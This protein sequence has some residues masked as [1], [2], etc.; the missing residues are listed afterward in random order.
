MTRLLRLSLALALLSA[1]GDDSSS[2]APDTGPGPRPDG[3]TGGCTGNSECDDGVACTRDLCDDETGECVNLPEGPDCT[4]SCERNADCDDGVACTRDLCD[5]E[6]GTCINAPDGPDCR[7]PECRLNAECD[8]DIDC[9][10]DVCDDE[11][12]ECVNVPIMDGCM[13]AECATAADCNDGVACTND[14]CTSGRCSHAA[15]ASMCPRDGC[16]QNVQCDPTMGCVGDARV[17]DD[18][19]ACTADSCD[20]A[21]GCVFAPDDS[22]CPS[23]NTCS[24]TEG[25]SGGTCSSAADCD[26]GD[27]CTTDQCSA[28]RCVRPPVECDDGNQCTD[29]ECNPADGRCTS[30]PHARLCDDGN[31]C[32]DGDRCSGGSCR[33]TPRSCS[34]GNPCT[35]DTCNPTSGAC[36]STITPSISCED[37]DPCTMGT[38]CTAAGACT[39]GSGGCPDDGNPCTVETCT[40]SGCATSNAPNGMSCGTGRQ[41]CNGACASTATDPMNCGSCGNRCMT[42]T[43]ACVSGACTTCATDADCNDDRDCTMDVCNTIA[44]RCEHP[45]MPG[46]CFIGGSCYSDNALNP[47]EECQRCNAAGTPTVWAP[48]DNAPCDDGLF[49]TIDD[50]CSPDGTC[51]RTTPNCNDGLGCTT[52][53]C[54]EATDAC[55]NVIDAGHCVYPEPG[56]TTPVCRS[57]GELWGGPPVFC[58]ACNAALS[59][60]MPTPARNGLCC[61]PVGG[62]G[63]CTDGEC[64]PT[65]MCDTGM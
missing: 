22:L 11:T 50:R 12:G 47:A 41:C 45:I 43:N 30:T 59:Q 28:G 32:T 15:D 33:S 54:S 34:D 37:G 35:A 14:T 39:G 24:T 10:N 18:G 52:D 48:R 6:T 36:N 1:C 62:G 51:T 9:T 5:D 44:R 2:G 46:R 26:D 13:S 63:T 31:G 7:P 8:D 58:N 29:D 57:P 21:T 42:P 60:T 38:T 40:G 17:C 19:V 16:M 61:V 49:C 65:A 20:P 4:P 25:C 3:S 64:V 55:M 53:T 56:T 27:A 23:G